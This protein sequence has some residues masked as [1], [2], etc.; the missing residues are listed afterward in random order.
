MD[1]ILCLR[2]LGMLGVFT[3]RI[4]AT[5]MIARTMRTNLSVL[6][7]FG[8]GG[9]DAAG[10]C[11]GADAAG[12]CWDAAAAGRRRGAGGGW[13]WIQYLP[14]HHHGAI[15]F[16]PQRTEEGTR[17]WASCKAVHT[18]MVVPWNK[19]LAHCFHFFDC[20]TILQGSFHW[21]G[22]ARNGS[23][24]SYLLRKANLE[25]DTHLRRLHLTHWGLCSV[26][27]EPLHPVV[28]LYLF[29]SNHLDIYLK[30]FCLPPPLAN[31]DT[32]YRS[33]CFLHWLI[34]LGLRLHLS[35]LSYV[36][37]LSLV[38]HVF[39]K[40]HRFWPIITGQNIQL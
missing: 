19:S 17:A 10:C 32:R 37:H 11:C 22:H 4:L 7:W 6:V 38:I 21:S 40:R 29:L 34:T 24:W 1:T 13:R 25:F 27:K 20:C 28:C 14:H 15:I 2:V 31:N 36:L 8:G 35:T 12:C 18:E 33:S 23:K 30:K 39:V 3:F 5:T 26:K 9:A 16:D